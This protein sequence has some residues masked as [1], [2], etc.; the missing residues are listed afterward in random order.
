MRCFIAIDLPKELQERTM[1]IEKKL[2]YPF[3]KLVK[4]QNLHLTLMFLGEI[5]EKKVEDVKSALTSIKFP[6]FEIKVSGIGCFPNMRSPRVIFL[7]CHSSELNKLASEIE[8]KM[9]S[10]GIRRDKPFIAHITLA[11]VK[12]KPDENLFKVLEE[13]RHMEL[14]KFVATEFK[15]KRSVLTPSGPIYSD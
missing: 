6:K 15:L 13:H 9:S 5:D 11:R 10:L 1:E 7:N 12:R 4:P 2:T 3:V 14:G 8:K